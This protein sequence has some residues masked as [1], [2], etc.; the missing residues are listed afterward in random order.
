MRI[1]WEFLSILTAQ[2]SSQNNPIRISRC[3]AEPVILPSNWEWEIPQWV[4]PH[5][6]KVNRVGESRL[7]IKLSAICRGVTVSRIP[8]SSVPWPWPVP[9]PAVIPRLSWAFASSSPPYLHVSSSSTCPVFLVSEVK[10]AKCN[11]LQLPPVR[12]KLSLDF[13]GV[14]KAIKGLKGSSDLAD[15]SSSGLNHCC[16]LPSSSPLLC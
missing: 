3:G 7:V 1:I 10:S 4:F 9:S 12:R 13:K 14:Q 8:R 15:C 5:R 2:T 6:I 11:L 16:P